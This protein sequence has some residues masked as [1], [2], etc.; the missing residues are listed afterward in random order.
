MSE[1]D[2]A[3]ISSNHALTNS[4]EEP[5]IERRHLSMNKPNVKESFGSF[6]KEV[7]ALVFTAVIIALAIRWLIVQPF[8]IPSPSME[9]TLKPGDRVLVSKFIYKFTEPSRGDVIVFV[10]PNGDGRDFIKRI[11]AVEGDVV[12]IK[13]GE[14]FINEKS[15]DGKYETMPGDFSNW[16]PQ[17]IA[18]N[19]VF[20][21]GDNRPNSMD[22]RVFGPLPE[23][24]IVGRAFV[25]YW[26]ASRLN[27]LN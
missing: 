9:P 12:Q 23:S 6:L 25:I 24:N 14:L 4:A 27:I 26:P 17:K 7:P 16:G 5:L 11:V 8:Y 3:G 21:M 19:H 2:R 22:G 18:K 15:A 1:E 10:A 13:D 20:V